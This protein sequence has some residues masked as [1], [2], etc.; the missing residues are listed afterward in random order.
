M[1]NGHVILGL[2]DFILTFTVFLIEIDHFLR[3]QICVGD[4]KEI[5]GFFTFQEG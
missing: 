4:K 3:G 5:D 1:A 2:L